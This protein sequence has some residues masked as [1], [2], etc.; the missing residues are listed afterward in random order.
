MQMSAKRR[1][2]LRWFSAVTA[3]AQA[4]SERAREEA[5]NLQRRPGGHFEPLRRT[6]LTS[7]DEEEEEVKTRPPYMLPLPLFTRTRGRVKVVGIGCVNGASV[8]N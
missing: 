2:R 4:D 1:R 3:S 5:L 8:V 7:D 6:K